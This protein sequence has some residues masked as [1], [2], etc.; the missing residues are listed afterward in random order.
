[1]D[2]LP[3]YI[4]T[5]CFLTGFART[6]MALR[7]GHYHHSRFNS[8]TMAAGF[9]FQ[10]LFLA[11]HGRAIK[12]CPLTNQFELLVF[13]S[14]SLVLLYLVVGRA[15]RLSLLGAFTA[16]L[17][18]FL[19]A[20]ALMTSVDLARITPKANLFLE[21]HAALSVIAYGAFGMAGIAGVMYL[22]QERQLKTRH[23][24]QIFFEMP[25]ITHLATTNLRLIWAGF[26]ILSL[27]LIAGVAVGKPTTQ[28]KEVWGLV[29]WVIYLAIIIVRRL[30]PRR[31]A[32]FSVMAFLVALSSLGWLNY[33]ATQP[34]P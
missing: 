12:H 32:L 7:A 3:L 27:G 18:L 31:I 9:V 19:Q 5:L 33:F 30:G 29:L 15:Y 26:L 20:A 25:P 8:V 2:R 28:A 22:A 21:L 14:W 34:L 1:M 24:R 10:T 11:L 17:V 13:L 16:P 4:A 6:V 23:L